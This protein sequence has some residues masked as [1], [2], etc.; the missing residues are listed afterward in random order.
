MTDLGRLNPSLDSQERVHTIKIIPYSLVFYSTFMAVPDAG[1]T[2]EEH[3]ACLEP[4]GRQPGKPVAL[5]DKGSPMVAQE[6]PDA[7]KG[8]RQ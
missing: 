6:P 2:M 5:G 4:S 1:F 8:N 3:S 7:E